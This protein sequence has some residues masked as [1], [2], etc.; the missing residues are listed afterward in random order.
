MIDYSRP[1]LAVT[2]LHKR[3]SIHHLGSQLT[4]FDA[5]TFS[6]SPGEFLLL[7]GEN[8]VGKSTLLKTL[9]RTC[10][11]QSGKAIYSTRDDETIDLLSASDRDI[12]TLRKK[13]IG[14]VTQFLQ[15][16]PRVSAEDIVSEAIEDDGVAPD[17][18]AETAR[19]E[20]LEFGLKPNLLQSYPSTFS[21]G[22]QQ[23]VNLARVLARPYRL[24]LLDEPTASLDKDSRSALARRL[25][26]LKKSGVSIIGVFHFT[27]DI[28]HLVDREIIL[29]RKQMPEASTES[30]VA[31]V[32]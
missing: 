19:K 11:A 1:R 14:F 22:E 7:K 26:E 31:H 13:E 32:A 24:L 3:Y 4:P 27:D 9:Y 20:L 16:R 17:S 23:K 12:T 21:G 29:T 25:G 5:I 2:D 6:V 28:K 15:S 30:G 8:G 10:R 18:A